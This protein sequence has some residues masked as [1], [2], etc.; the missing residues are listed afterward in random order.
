MAPSASRPS[1]SGRSGSSAE[2]TSRRA[3]PSLASAHCRTGPRRRASSPMARRMTQGVNHT[4]NA[5]AAA[6]MSTST[7]SRPAMA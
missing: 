2:L 6:R 1:V 7:T 4:A 3:Q 5:S